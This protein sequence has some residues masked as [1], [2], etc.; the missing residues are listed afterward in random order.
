M[1]IIINKANGKYVVVGRSFLEDKQLKLIDRG[2]LTTLLSLPLEWKFSINGMS[3]ILP[4][5]KKAIQS[6]LDRLIEKGYIIKRQERIDGKFGENYIEI[7]DKSIL[8]NPIAENRITDKSIS[9]N[10]TQYKYN[11]GFNNYKSN[12]EKIKGGEVA[13][14][15]KWSN[16]EQAFYKL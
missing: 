10:D 14:D 4:D 5:G 16:E 1:A 9:G 15:R 11:N 6:S 7:F 2:L 13:S 8:V 12:T 3:S